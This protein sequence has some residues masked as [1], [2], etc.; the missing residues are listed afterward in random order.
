MRVDGAIRGDSDVTGKE[1]PSTLGDVMS[2]N[3]EHP[4]AQPLGEAEH[5][6]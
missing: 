2:E 1:D 5:L 4:F 3:V 6:L